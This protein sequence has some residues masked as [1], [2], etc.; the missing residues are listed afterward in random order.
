MKNKILI[1]IILFA[2]LGISQSSLAATTAEQTVTG[3]LGPFRNVVTDGGNLTATILPNSGSLNTFIN[4]S[5]LISTNTSA[6]QN[7]DLLAN[8]VCSDGDA[9]AFS[10]KGIPAGTKY[11]ALAHA[12]ILPS[13]ANVADALSPSP[14]IAS[15]PN[16]I[17]YPVTGPVDTAGQLVF[18]W[19][20]AT[21]KY[22]GN[23]THK[24]NTPTQLVIPAGIVTPN[25]FGINDSDGA[26]LTAVTLAFNPL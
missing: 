1:S 24:G 16:V 9:N 7:L 15:N 6:S 11:I 21:R 5:F 2:I 12:T 17:V 4:P 25:T 3:T 20:T 23:L 22:T 13:I 19:Q 26:Y 8:C 10:D 14:N 18:T